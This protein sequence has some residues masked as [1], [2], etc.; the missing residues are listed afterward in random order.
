[1]GV[2]TLS[3][4][5]TR[6]RRSFNAKYIPNLHFL[7]QPS[8]VAVDFETANRGGGV[9]ACQVAL[10]KMEDGQVTD[11]FSTFI[12]P[13]QGYS[14]F[15][16]TWLHG[17]GPRQVATA[18]MWDQIADQIARF[19]GDLPVYAHNAMFD[20]RVWKDLDDYFGILSLPHH[21]F[22]SYLTARR[23]LPGLENYALPTVLHECDPTFS[24]NHH[25]AGSDAH[26][27]ARIVRHLASRDDLHGAL[28]P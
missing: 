3:E 9:S 25:E 19:V 12:Q 5:R 2:L 1:M 14:R 24:L 28:A 11:E 15:E 8:F 4:Q 16:F 18:P 7:T 13:P 22:C 27:C 17:I 20:A 10:V 23:M 21:F 26:A 6:S